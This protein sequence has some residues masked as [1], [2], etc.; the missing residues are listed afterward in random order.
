MV[1]HGGLHALY[2]HSLMQVPFRRRRSWMLIVSNDRAVAVERVRDELRRLPAHDSLVVVDAAS[3]DG[4]VDV[5]FDALGSDPRLRIVAL[6]APDVDPATACAGH[7][8]YLA[9]D[10]LT[11]RRLRSSQKLGLVLEEPVPL[12]EPDA[13]VSAG[14]VVFLPAASYHLEEL[15]PLADTL[16][17]QGIPT[18]FYATEWRWDDVVRRLR[19][20]RQPVF[21][22]DD[23]LSWVDGAAAIVTLNDWAKALQPLIERAN[24]SGV[25]TFAKVE[26]V[27]DF[28]DIDVHWERRAYRTSSLTLCQGTNDRDSLAGQPTE[29]VGNSRLE[30]IWGLPHVERE[31]NVA[32]I[33]LNFTYGVLEEARDRW[34]AEVVEAVRHAGLEPLVSRHPAENGPVGDVAVSEDPMSHLLTTAAVLVSR[35]STVPFESMARG[36]PFVYYN[37]HGEKVLAFQDPAGAYESADDPASLVEAILQAV[38]SGPTSRDRA[39]NFFRDQ[40][41]IDPDRSSAS[42]AADVIGGVLR[43]SPDPRH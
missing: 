4:T 2:S 26:G 12:R 31:S 34:L 5:I 1:R 36:T 38:V 28:D 21:G 27:Q 10:L 30:R 14:R 3:S 11:K 18:A 13:S 20:Q 25:P 16:E 22:W 35:F 23:S 39:E 7:A 33:N 9:Y 43:D 8:P 42:R 37:P 41:D 24:A 6:D 17:L 19:R 40:V 32:V 15:G 29:I